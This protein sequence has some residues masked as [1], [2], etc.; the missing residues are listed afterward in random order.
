M[1]EMGSSPSASTMNSERKHKTS[2]SW[3]SRLK[4]NC[5]TFAVSCRESFS[6]VKA[7]FIGQA[8]KI[9]AKN[10]KEATAADLDT[11]KMQV[12]AADAA[13]KTKN[14]LNKSL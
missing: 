14:R 4:K 3:L 1:D 6:Y 12:E 13:E 7:F 8:K 11:A 2:S 9:R 10:E 5:L